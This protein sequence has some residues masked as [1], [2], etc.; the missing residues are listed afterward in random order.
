MHKYLTL[1]L[2]LASG[3]LHA[4]Q[5]YGFEADAYRHTIVY[6]DYKA[7]FQLQSAAAVPKTIVA[8]KKYYWYSNNQIKIT[9]GGYS[10]KLLNGVYH[11]FY[12]NNN[13]KAQGRFELGLK[14][15]E[16]NAWGTEGLLTEKINYNKG[17]PN[18]LFY[19]YNSQGLLY[20][21]GRYKD[22]KLN[23]AIKTYPKPDSMV[24]STYKNG[25]LQIPR[26]SFL[27]RLLHKKPKPPIIQ[28]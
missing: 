24:V 1:A 27:K 23:G 25:I 5:N 18:G 13:L 14:M 26:P 4:Q 2:L 17:V 3:G 16:W 12:L 10:G 19:K 11:D 7:V 20:E 9:Q 22:G 8:Q 21:T 15:G 28:N 6:P